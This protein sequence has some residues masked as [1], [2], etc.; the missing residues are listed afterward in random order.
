MATIKNFEDLKVWQD[1]RVLT[2]RVYKMTNQGPF[3][4]NFGLRDQIR[5]AAGSTMHN[6]AE[7]FDANS[8]A[9]FIQF[10][11]YSRRSASE[12]QSQLYLALDQNYIEKKE[13][14][15]VYDLATKLK[16]QINGFSTYLKK[17]KNKKI[18]E[19]LTHYLVDND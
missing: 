15:E 4:K 11:G 19:E 17:S 18:K 1:S 8:D 9:Q 6:I 7:G 3:S 10:L 16:K 12:V 2:N 14:Q 13:F 5:R